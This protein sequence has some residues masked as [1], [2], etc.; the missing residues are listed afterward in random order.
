MRTFEITKVNWS[1]RKNNGHNWYLK[2]LAF[3][4]LLLFARGNAELFHVIVLNLFFR[5]YD[6]LRNAGTYVMAKS[7]RRKFEVN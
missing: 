1:P 6:I 3:K 4:L 2:R 5:Y 7:T